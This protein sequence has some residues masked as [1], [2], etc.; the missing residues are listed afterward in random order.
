[1]PAENADWPKLRW[2]E[3]PGGK[4]LDAKVELFPDHF[5]LQ[6]RGGTKGTT[7]ARNTD[8]AQALGEICRRA[9]KGVFTRIIIDSEKAREKCK[10]E[11]RVLLTGSDMEGLSGGELTAIIRRK[12]REFGQ[13]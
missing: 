11:D 8:Y 13:D 10:L 3:G 1:M 2:V 12:L 6:S 7:S 5:I 9:N 4:P